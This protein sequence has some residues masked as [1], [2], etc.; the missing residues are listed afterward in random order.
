[1]SGWFESGGLPVG[2]PSIAACLGA[3]AVIVKSA[4]SPLMRTVRISANAYVFFSN[5]S[6]GPAMLGTRGETFPTR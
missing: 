3:V 6:R 5:L 1:M 4:V 2:V